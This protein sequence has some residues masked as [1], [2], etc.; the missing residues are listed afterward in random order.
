M[1]LY[2]IMTSYNE[3]YIRKL[4]F[5]FE[6]LLQFYLGPLWVGAEDHGDVHHVLVILLNDFLVQT[7]RQIF[8]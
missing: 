8:A 2:F 4:D 7:L 6:R 1:M 3:T 5:K